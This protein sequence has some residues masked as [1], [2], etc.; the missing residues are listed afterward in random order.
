MQSAG[1]QNPAVRV[2]IPTLLP[3]CSLVQGAL[4]GGA[5]P[6]SRVAFRVGPVLGV[7]NMARR[8]MRQTSSRPIVGLDLCR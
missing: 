2:Q 8:H 6:P 1:L 3:I 5:A 7:A 4:T